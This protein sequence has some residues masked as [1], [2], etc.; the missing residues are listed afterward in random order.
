MTV[1]VEIGVD[2]VAGVLAAMRAGADRVEL[3]AAAAE[4]GLTPSAGLVERAVAVAGDRVG[5]HVLVR[6]RPGGFHYAREELAVMRRDVA[7]A[8]ECGAAGIVVGA[9]DAGGRVDRVCG[10]LVAAA[11]GLPVTFHRALDVAEDSVR[12]LEDVAALGF[13]RVLTSGRRRSVLDGLPLV[14]ELVER[15]AGRVAVMACGG[16]RAGNARQVLAATGVHD[17]HAAMR[18]PVGAAGDGEVSFAGI[19]V[20]TGF[21]R[22]DTDPDEAAALCRIARG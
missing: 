8:R 19:G 15:A 6:P 22:F 2:S 20:P 11:G 4:G 17:L 16:V 14:R 1:R 18:R 13:V 9:L 3:C 7:L 5:V 21:D 10:D 12:A